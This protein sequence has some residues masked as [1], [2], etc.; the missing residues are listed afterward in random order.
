M[1][2]KPGKKA[3]AALGRLLLW[4]LVCAAAALPAVYMNSIYGY[5]PVLF[6]AAL[7]GLSRLGL[8]SLR[9]NLRA[10]T[11][12]MSCVSL[13]GQGI[14][15]SMTLING[16]LFFCPKARATM[17]ISDLFG[18]DDITETVSF[19]IAGKE[20]RRFAFDMDMAHVGVFT[21]GLSQVELY[22]FLG[23][24]RC[25]LPLKCRVSACIL[26]RIYPLERVYSAEEAAAEA[27]TDTR[28][29]VFGGTDYTGVRE[30]ALGDPI[31]QIHWK[32][33]AHCRDYMT[34]IQESCRQQSFDV[35]L[36]FVTEKGRDRELL[37]TINDTLIETA[38][39]LVDDISRH[40]A[41]YS[42][43]YY[44]KNNSVVGCTPLVEEQA[45]ELVRSFSVI[46][47]EDDPYAS[48]AFTM[49]QARSRRPGRSTNTL[50]VTSR[51]TSSLVAELCRI[52]AQH[53]TPELFYV[54]PADWDSRQRSDAAIVLKQL[55]EN[56]IAW[57][58]VP[59]GETVESHD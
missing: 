45:A 35:I 29:T 32:L 5:L 50:V 36:D 9:R 19:N 27:S 7:L 17:Y 8:W 34:K 44:S 10:E 37:M 55:D 28:I 13:R 33:S 58:F 30:Y 53:R 12:D 38:L 39:S 52:R 41:D 2:R 51:V 18:G 14:T 49:L 26:P 1:R 11:E 54:I 48:D 24:F 4:L 31:K 15:L 6:L 59:A 16:S 25:T 23:V 21:V 56:D 43:I 3:A 22:D 20:H 42:L 57:S 46:T 47:T 40:E